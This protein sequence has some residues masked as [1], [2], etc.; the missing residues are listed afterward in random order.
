MDFSILG[1]S[2][3]PSLDSR[4]DDSLS[5]CRPQSL[6]SPYLLFRCWNGP[7]ALY[8]STMTKWSTGSYGSGQW[9]YHQGLLLPNTDL[10]HPF[11][12]KQSCSYEEL[13]QYQ[14]DQRKTDKRVV[15]SSGWSLLCP[16]IPHALMTAGNSSVPSCLLKSHRW[17][18]L[19]VMMNLAVSLY[20]LSPRTPPTNSK[21]SRL[22]FFGWPN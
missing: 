16:G 18:H 15:D 20:Q 7:L 4:R 22:Y 8:L 10:Y 2:L 13:A 1:G 17:L 5:N 21:V 9:T 14:S 19:F 12:Q 6:N 11:P 3:S